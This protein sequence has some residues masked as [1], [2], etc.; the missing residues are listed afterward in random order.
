MRSGPKRT[1]SANTGSGSPPRSRAATWSCS[2]RDRRWIETDV[3]KAS[4][5]AADLSRANIQYEVLCEDDFRLPRL[6][7]AMALL[8]ESLSVLN[9]AEKATADEFRRGGGVVI[10]SDSGDWLQRIKSEAG[11]P[12]VV[13]QGPATVRAVVRDRPQQTLVH[14][15]NLNIVRRSSF[16]DEVHPAE[17]VRLTVRVPFRSGCS[18]QAITADP[19][20]TSGN[21]PAD[22]HKHTQGCTVEICRSPPGRVRHSGAHGFSGLTN[23]ELDRINKMD[24]NRRASAESCKSCSSCPSTRLLRERPDSHLQLSGVVVQFAGR[25]V[26]LQKQRAAF[27]GRERAAQADHGRVQQGRSAPRF[28]MIGSDRRQQDAQRVTV[29]IANRHAPRFAPPNRA[30]GGRLHRRA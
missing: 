6:Q 26:D 20:G 23:M 17:N 1:C 5:L 11:V 8:V 15:L 13:V 12:S 2:C 18:V 7:T 14:L 25:I 22:F 24:K 3:C 16:E 9:A 28:R 21:L 10:A 27:L 4:T 29:I 30:V 19:H